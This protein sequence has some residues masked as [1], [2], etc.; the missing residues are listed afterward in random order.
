MSSACTANRVTGSVKPVSKRKK[1]FPFLVTPRSRV[2]CEGGACAGADG[3]GAGASSAPRS[4][5]KERG[6]RRHRRESVLAIGATACA[7]HL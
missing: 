5:R 1:A 7:T 2:P 3:R 6:T 4:P